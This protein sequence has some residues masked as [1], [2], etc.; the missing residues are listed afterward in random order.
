MMAVAGSLL[1]GAVVGAVF[2]LA[3]LPIPAPPTL[4]GVAGVVGVWLGYTVAGW[5]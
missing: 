4:A 2:G 3:G 1:V 5:A